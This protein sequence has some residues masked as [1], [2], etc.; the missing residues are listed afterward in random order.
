M[1]GPPGNG[2]MKIKPEKLIFQIVPPEVLS[3][4]KF[5][6]R[7]SMYAA[8]L[9][10]LIDGAAAVS[11]PKEAA[12]NSMQRCAKD[13]G[14]EIQILGRANGSLYFKLKSKAVARGT[15]GGAT[16]DHIVQLAKVIAK[17]AAPVQ[18]TQSASEAPAVKK[19]ESAAAEPAK[20]VR[21][22]SSAAEFIILS[23]LANGPK[24]GYDLSIALEKAGAKKPEA[25]VAQFLRPLVD[26]NRIILQ[27]AGNRKVWRLAVAA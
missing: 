18:E 17:V 3:T 22:A 15:G 20:T 12:R 13:M 16:P 10:A 26:G 27:E 8:A 7:H 11:I 25:S 2:R 1:E 19:A 24:T 5:E 9:Q 4:V 21:S 14:I 6:K 23:E